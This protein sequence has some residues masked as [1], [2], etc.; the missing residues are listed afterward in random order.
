MSVLTTFRAHPLSHLAGF[1]LGTLPVVVLMGHRA[2]APELVTAYVCL[3]T[4]PHANVRWSF[5][6]LGKVI[7]SPAYHRL[8]HAYEGAAGL[9]LGWMVAPPGT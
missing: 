5:G 4:L 8:H 2:M 3:G 1:F 7:V 6:P 9:N